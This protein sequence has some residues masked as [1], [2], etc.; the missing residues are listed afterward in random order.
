MSFLAGAAVALGE[1]GSTI[2]NVV[3]QASKATDALQI[4]IG[5]NATGKNPIFNINP[6][7]ENN[8]SEYS[9]DDEAIARG[10]A[11]N[12]NRLATT[13]TEGIKDIRDH[14]SQMIVD[15]HVHDDFLLPG[16]DGFAKRL[17]LVLSELSRVTTMLANQKDQGHKLLRAAE[18]AGVIGR[19]VHIQGGSAAYI[20]AP[21]AV[22]HG[23]LA[24]LRGQTALIEAADIFARGE[25]YQARTNLYAVTSERFAS[26][27]KESTTLATEGVVAILQKAG[28][29]KA[30]VL[31]GAKNVTVKSL[32]GKLTLHSDDDLELLSA[33]VAKLLG[34]TAKVQ[35]ANG[36]DIESG[37]GI[38]IKA[39]G[40]INLGGGG[41]IAAPATPE[42]ETVTMPEFDVIVP[43]NDDRK[44]GILFE[45]VHGRN[46]APAN[47]PKANPG[48]E[49][50]R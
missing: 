18:T 16:G 40:M 33:K 49:M 8:P 13:L 36:V 15:S 22:V 31:Q 14:V 29:D 50:N 7:E 46:P 23:R 28:V 37:A 24:V 5:Q 44:A 38:N 11:I 32:A 34:R 12:L 10:A 26:F 4:L 2:S 47:V 39:S 17:S 25:T 27:S 9:E 30:F 3:G 43:N 6:P 42:E 41:A 1:V 48:D 35:G 19:L 21:L 45:T 20:E